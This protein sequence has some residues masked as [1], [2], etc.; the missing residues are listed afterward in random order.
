MTDVEDKTAVLLRALWVR[1]R[2]IVEERL[3]TLDRG[4]AAV[5]AGELSEELRQETLNTAHKLAGALGMYGYHEGTRIA[6]ELEDLLGEASPDA[7]RLGALIAVLRAS[8][9]PA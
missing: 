9:F 1:N 7:A 5:A 2:P 4:A 6:R 8:I 3:A